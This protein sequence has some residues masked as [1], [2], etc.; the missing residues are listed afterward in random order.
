MYAVYVTASAGT[1]AATM[2]SRVFFA[3][4]KSVRLTNL[5]RERERENARARAKERAR[6]NKEN[7]R[8]ETQTEIVRER[9]G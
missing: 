2:V 3:P 5:K 1:P 7:E 6:E 9:G 4:L 8:D